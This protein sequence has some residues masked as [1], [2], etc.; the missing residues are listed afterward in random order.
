M[1]NVKMYRMDGTEAGQI[2]LSDEVFGVEVNESLLH[3]AVVTTLSNKRQG[4]QSALTRAEVRGG[5]IKPFRQKGTGH[6]R[7]GSSRAPQYEAGGVVFAPKPRSYDKKLNR[8]QKQL[9]MK[10]ALSMK[11]M[12]NDL[13]VVEEIKFD[14]PK[15]KDAVAMLKNLKAEGKALIVTSEKDDNLILSAR[16]IPGTETSVAGAFGVYD[17]MN[18]GK[19]ILT[20]DAVSAIE[21]VYAK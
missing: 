4:T 7:Q 14:A 12:D 17:V 6:A 8:K 19:L 21:E 11:V 9:A 13:I 15:T 3:Q 16:N 5:G 20:K 2:E 1:P 10:S 18:C